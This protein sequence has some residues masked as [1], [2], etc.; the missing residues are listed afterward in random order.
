[1][2]ETCFVLRLFVCGTLG[3]GK[4]LSDKLHLLPDL[5]GARPQQGRYNNRNIFLE[6][7]VCE[8]EG[9]NDV[10]MPRVAKL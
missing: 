1:M 3:F 2:P 5:T 8:H 9:H 4:V 7:T 10:M 6:D